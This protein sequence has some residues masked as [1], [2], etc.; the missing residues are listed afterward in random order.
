[1]AIHICLKIWIICKYC[2]TKP[3][4]SKLVEVRKALKL[5]ISLLVPW[6][7]LWSSRWVIYCDFHRFSQ[8]HTFCKSCDFLEYWWVLSWELWVPYFTLKSLPSVGKSVTNLQTNLIRV[9]LK[10][11]MV[12]AVTQSFFDLTLKMSR[13]KMLPRFAFYFV[14]IT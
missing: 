6:K 3:K 2:N 7:D 12:R 9:D 10:E 4:P 11:N 8:P 14:H 1:M 13:L 5:G